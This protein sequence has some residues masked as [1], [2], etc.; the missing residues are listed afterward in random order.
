M[1]EPVG[2]PLVVPAPLG[3]GPSRREAHRERISSA[4]AAHDRRPRTPTGSQP[5]KVDLGTLGWIGRCC[6]PRRGRVVDLVVESRRR[7][8]GEVAHHKGPTLSRPQAAGRVHTRP[9]TCAP[10]ESCTYDH[11]V[12]GKGEAATAWDARRAPQPPCTT[13]PG[14]LAT[15]GT[16]SRTRSDSRRRR[17]GSRSRAARGYVPTRP[18][19]TVLDAHDDPTAPV[20]VVLGQQRVPRCRAAR[21]LRVRTNRRAV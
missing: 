17:R 15:L 16:S 13:V 6:R 10:L 12:P 20:A 11:R 3:I 18:R 2:E 8:G 4:S 1:Q 9:V 7:A 5:R 14:A 21:C 19:D